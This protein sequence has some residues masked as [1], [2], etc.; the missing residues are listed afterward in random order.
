MSQSRSTKIFVSL[1][2]LYTVWGSTYLAQRV[3]VSTF[4]PLQMAGLASRSRAVSSWRSSASAARSSPR[5]RSGERRRYP[6][7]R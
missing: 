1:A 3:A 7:R 2:V 4:T 6:R 5:A